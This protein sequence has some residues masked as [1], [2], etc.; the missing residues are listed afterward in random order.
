MKISIPTKIKI[1]KIVTWICL[2]LSTYLGIWTL[3]DVAQQNEI[4]RT[5]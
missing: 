3:Y 5:K 4:Q 2:C 1:L